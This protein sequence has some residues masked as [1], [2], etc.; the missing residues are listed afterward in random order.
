MGLISDS[1]ALCHANLLSCH[2]T[3]ELTAYLPKE[4]SAGPMVTGIRH[5]E[6]WRKILKY[7]ECYFLLAE[8]AKSILAKSVAQI[9]WN[10]TGNDE[11]RLMRPRV[12]LAS[13]LWEEAS[14]IHEAKSILNSHL[15]N[16]TV[17]PPNLR[18][19]SFFKLL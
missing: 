18:G 4:M 5:L 1:F 2:I 11:I 8:F 16:A 15:I 3:M 6:K 7:S 12:L 19:V 9:G 17:I 10:D 14:A 13:V